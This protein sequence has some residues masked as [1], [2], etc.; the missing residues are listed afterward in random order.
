[1]VEAFRIYHF[2]EPRLTSAE[3]DLTHYKQT[4]V[5]R[6]LMISRDYDVMLAC[7][8]RFTSYIIVLRVR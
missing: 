1:M 4:A 2:C 3:S 5:K 8:L 6:H 7:C